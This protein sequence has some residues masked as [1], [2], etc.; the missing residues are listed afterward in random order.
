VHPKAFILLAR[1]IG[2]FF[3]SLKMLRAAGRIKGLNL[4]FGLFSTGRFVKICA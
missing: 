3:H 1:Q 2:G 4:E